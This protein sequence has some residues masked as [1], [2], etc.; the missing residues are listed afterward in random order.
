MSSLKK[1]ECW[2]VWL[3]VNITQIILHLSVG[4]VFMSIVSGLYLVNGIW[5]LVTWMKLYKKKA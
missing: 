1:W 5:S 3:L 2:I 4:N